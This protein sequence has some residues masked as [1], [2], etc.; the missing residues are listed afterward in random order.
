MCFSVV[1]A[2]LHIVY[3]SCYVTIELFENPFFCLDLSSVWYWK[4][5]KSSLRAEQLS[6]L[7]LNLISFP[8]G[9][10]WIGSSR[11]L[12]KA[13]ILRDLATQNGKAC[14]S[15]LAYWSEKFSWLANKLRFVVNTTWTTQPTALDW[16]QKVTKMKPY[17]PGLFPEY[18]VTQ[19]QFSL[20]IF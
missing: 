2:L 11:R 12:S 10:F 5:N 15:I 14:V 7:F 6:L 8:F 16:F 18:R 1:F 3:I 4:G 19:K 13:I 17:V 9:E 20:G